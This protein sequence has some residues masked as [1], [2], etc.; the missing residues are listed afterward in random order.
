[1][2]PERGARSHEHATR[3]SGGTR[4]DAMTPGETDEKSGA[5]KAGVTVGTRVR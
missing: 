5:R 2:P 3:K 4:R 1:M